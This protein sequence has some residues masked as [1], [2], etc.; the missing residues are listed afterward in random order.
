MH[1]GWAFVIAL[2]VVTLSMRPLLR[3]LGRSGIVDV[4][5]HR[6]SHEVITPRGGGIAVML[7]VVA[8][9]ISIAPQPGMIEL[10]ALAASAACIGLVDDLRSLPAVARL[11]GQAS[12]AAVAVS[13]SGAARGPLALIVASALAVLV[14]GYINAFNFMDGINGI[15]ALSA[16]VSAGWYVYLGLEVGD[17]ALTAGGAA[18]AGASVGFLP[19]NAPAAKVF[20]GDVGSYGLGMFIAGLMLMSI[21]AGV[22]PVLAVAPLLLYFA[23]TGWTLIRRA[24]RRASWMEAHREHVYQRMCD[25]GLSH[26]SV[27]ALVAV[28]SALVCLVFAGLPLSVAGLTSGALLCG[29]LSLPS[30]GRATPAPR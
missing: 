2:A 4:P 9:A 1:E 22:H 13:L 30:F 11:L 8:G 16:V 7:G 10:C 3:M 14:V 29:Y 23:D 17:A 25:R 21:A 24:R 27:A 18:L 15:S 6:S 20:L 26:L 28:F 5:N 19:W 12:L